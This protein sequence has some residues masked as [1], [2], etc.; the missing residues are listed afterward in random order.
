M[1]LEGM[2]LSQ[3]PETVNVT[4]HGKGFAGAIKKKLLWLFWIL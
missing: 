2:C 4:I 1:G 3:T